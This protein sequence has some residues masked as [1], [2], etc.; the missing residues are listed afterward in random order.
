M[1]FSVLSKCR[2]QLMGVAILL[3]ALFHSSIVHANPTIDMICF[4]G[5]MGVDMF[6]FLSG[7]GMF[8]TYRKDTKPLQFYKKR[9]VRIVP[10]W[11]LVNLY[12]QLDQVGFDLTKLQLTSFVKYMTGFS[13]WL[14]GNL[15]FWYIP[16]ALAFYAM[17]PAFMW[18]YKKNKKQA[19]AVFSII[20][21]ALL[22]A[23]IVFQNAS[24]FIFLFRW[25]VFFLGILFGE[26]SYQK[27]KIKKAYVLSMALLLILGFFMENVIR[28][29]NGRYGIRYDYKYFIYVLISIPICVILA[30]A[31]DKIQYNFGSLRLLGG[32]TLEIY[33][34]HEYILRK[35]T[36][37]MGTVPFDSFGIW[38]NVL[39]FVGT[40]GVAWVLHVILAYLERTI[41]SNIA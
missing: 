41:R 23:S 26:F 5:D 20:W 21:I 31:M 34:L 37:W 9:M 15:Y 7:M 18:M 22:G 19:Y 38:F 6:F 40:V 11:F 14:E 39:V 8:Y 3:V 13:F 28:M 27:K 10:A 12:I 24:Y 2:G 29:Y 35:V 16:A 25:P 36:I 32:I 4:I 30:L 33:L 1:D 17:T